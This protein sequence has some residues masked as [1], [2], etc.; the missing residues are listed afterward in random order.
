MFGWSYTNYSQSYHF[1]EDLYFIEHLLLFLFLETLLVN[2]FDSPERFGL[3]VHALPDL[4]VGAYPRQLSALTLA[5]AGRYF[6]GVFDVPRV[7]SDEAAR[8]HL[9][10][11][12]H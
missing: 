6:V 5:N 7:F 11:F 8:V 10:T 12:Y 9:E 3:L 1:L 4:S 2:N